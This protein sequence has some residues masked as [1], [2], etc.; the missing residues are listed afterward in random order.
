MGIM[1]RRLD[2]LDIDK[3]IEHGAKRFEELVVGGA[4]PERWK[5]KPEYKSLVVYT[6]GAISK[7]KA[8]KHGPITT[9]GIGGI[10]ACEMRDSAEV[11]F[12]FCRA[13][14]TMD[15]GE[16]EE[17]LSSQSAELRATIRGLKSLLTRA[18][19]PHREIYGILKTVT[20]VTDSEYVVGGAKN[21]LAKWIKNGW[22]TS[23][24]NPVKHQALWEK[25][26]QVQQEFKELGV[27]LSFRHT[28]GHAGIPGNEIAD[29]LAT[30]AVAERLSKLL[31]VNVT[32]SDKRVPNEKRSGVASAAN[33]GTRGKGTESDTKVKRSYVRSPL[34][35][36][37]EF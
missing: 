17:G 7:R 34:K 24:G 22:L 31:E 1:L 27:S 16:T 21:H 13:A 15:E 32:A 28:P 4:D 20:L 8:S 25:L 29:K 33:I 18:T 14:S 10:C 35:K 3:M 36:K 26:H 30:R 23:I 6:D 2:E 9:I 12:Y 37:E 5:K 11:L 19:L